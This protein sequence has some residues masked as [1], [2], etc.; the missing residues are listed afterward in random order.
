MS[1]GF[2]FPISLPWSDATCTCKRAD[3]CTCGSKRDHH[4]DVRDE[5][6]HYFLAYRQDVYRYLRYVG[7]E[8]VEAED[9]TQETFLRLYRERLDGRHIE[10]DGILPWVLTVARRISVDR[11]R[12]RQLEVRLFTELSPLLAETLPDDGQTY[13]DERRE[14]QRRAFL[15]GAIQQL[16]TLERQCLHLRANGHSLQTVGEIVNMSVKGVS[17]TVLRAI[18]R[19]RTQLDALA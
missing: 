11:L 5:V 7:C 18:R 16:S 8:T 14:R 15:I 1:S 10:R 13:E 4:A 12:R 3:V 2:G 9:A 17:R 19:L 6:T